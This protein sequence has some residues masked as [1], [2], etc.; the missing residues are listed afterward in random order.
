M[1]PIMT[2][3]DWIP[4][5][6]MA[7]ITVTKTHLSPDSEGC[8]HMCLDEG[9]NLLFTPQSGVCRTYLNP[10][11]FFIRVFKSRY[12]AEANRPVLAPSPYL[13]ERVIGLVEGVTKSGVARLHS[14]D[15]RAHGR[16]WAR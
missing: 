14:V 5:S 8:G 6:D 16:S 10:L 12:T 13:V 7:S 2:R 1:I 3:E 11:T 4:H 9:P 15:R